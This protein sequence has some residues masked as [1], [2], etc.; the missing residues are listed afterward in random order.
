MVFAMLN[1]WLIFSYIL[2]S[3]YFILKYALKSKTLLDQYR[4]QGFFVYELSFLDNNLSI[5][6]INCNFFNFFLF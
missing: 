4:Q 2:Y 6:D 1:A 3:S 5:H